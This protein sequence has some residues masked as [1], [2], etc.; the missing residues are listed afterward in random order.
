MKK[1]KEV[2]S[3]FFF[4]AKKAET[5]RERERGK[6]RRVVERKTHS[7]LLQ[8]SKDSV[9]TVLLLH[10]G[11]K[12]L[13]LSFLEPVLEV[14]EEGFG[15]LVLVVGGLAKEGREGELDEVKG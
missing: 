6:E 11:R 1:R 4:Q 10:L 7:N 9:E 14:L 15:V 5:E 2:R 13:D 12:S 3:C 8:C